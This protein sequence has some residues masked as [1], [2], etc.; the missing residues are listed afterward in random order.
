[1][2]VNK[3]MAMVCCALTLFVYL[4]GSLAAEAQSGSQK[5]L[6]QPMQPALD[7]IDADGTVHVKDFSVPLSPYMSE[8]SKKRFIENADRA[9]R[10]AQAQHPP[11]PP[12]EAGAS[13][14]NQCP[15][16]AAADDWLR[17]LME[18]GKSLYPVN[19]EGRRIAGVQVD[20]ITPKGGTSARNRNRVLIQLRGGGYSCGFTGGKLGLVQSIPIAGVGKFKVIAVDY[21]SSPE[22]KFPAAA[23]DVAA[24]FREL[25]KSYKPDH[26]G[27]I[28]SS[29]GATLT[30]VS[31]AWLQRE[32]L[33][34]PGAIGLIGC[35]AEK[36]DVVDGDGWY[37]GNA[38][39]G[40]NVPAP[41]QTSEALFPE[42]YMS[43][44]DTKSPLVW[45]AKSLEVLSQ[46]PPTL[47]ISGTRDLCL[48]E[49]LY[50]HT[51]L[52]DADV[53]TELH[54]WEG[55]WHGFLNESDLPESIEA[56]KVI[57]KFFDAHLGQ[58]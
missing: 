30:A 10:S 36:D 35:G 39:V 32:K 57:A 9:R 22:Y 23:E 38:L 33:A 16:R 46:F 49:A 54:V 13:S 44:T 7:A 56:Y 8:A 51:R 29:T 1:L 50:T 42:P 19:V 31:V 12:T 5:A 4:H 52:V 55:M 45:P 58:I 34:R 15:E 26:I 17:P 2:K 41:G 18:R 25:L 47:L 11:H 6:N 37:M 43:G 53:T 28:G 21:R 14:V 40:N 24:V 3:A 27:I 20:V 48:S